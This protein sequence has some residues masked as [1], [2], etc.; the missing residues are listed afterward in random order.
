MV[1][2]ELLAS[3]QLLAGDIDRDCRISVFDVRQVAGAYGALV[4][5]RNVVGDQMI[6]LEDVAAVAMRSG[7]SCLAD[8]ALPGTGAGVATFSLTASSQQVYVGETFHVVIAVNAAPVAST[9]EPNLGG[10]GLVLH[11]DPH[12]VGVID[13][14]LPETATNATPVGPAIDNASGTVAFGAMS[15]A[16]GIIWGDTLATITLIGRG[17]GDTA[18]TALTAEAVDQDGR[19]LQAEAQTSGAVLRIEGQ[20][21]FLPVTGR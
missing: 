6:R 2:P 8:I 20:Q 7:A 9:G 17:V 5:E 15:P 21:I 3:R 12:K 1:A 16:A 19:T 10:F 18:L 14:Q 11:F 4:V 13:V